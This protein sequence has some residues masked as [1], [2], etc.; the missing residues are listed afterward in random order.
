MFEMF[1]KAC[2]LLTFCCCLVRNERGKKV[3][4]TRDLETGT[5]IELLEIDSQA[6][7]L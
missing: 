7:D 1:V 6:N 2:I 5:S 4:K 3:I